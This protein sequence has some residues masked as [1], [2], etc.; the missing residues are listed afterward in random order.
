MYNLNVKHFR[1]SH[2][3]QLRNQE[4]RAAYDEILLVFEDKE[5]TIEYVAEAFDDAK[6]ESKKLVILRNLNKK[7]HL[8]KTIRELTLNRFDYFTVIT[9]TVKTALKS[10]KAAERAAAKI[11]SEWLEPYKK[12]LQRPLI[13]VQ[14]TLIEE[15]ADE[16]DIKPRIDD[17]I[18]SLDL[19]EVLDS[20]KI[21][22]ADIKASINK[23]NS[24]M[25]A[26]NRKAHQTKRS[27]YAKMVIFLNSVEMVLN[28]NGEDKATYLRYANEVNRH[29][30]SYKATILSR[31][32]RYKNAAEKDEATSDVDNN[33]E[34]GIETTSATTE[35]NVALRSTPY[36]LT[37][38]IDK[39]MDMDMQSKEKTN[40]DSTTTDALTDNVT[41][42][43]NGVLTN[44]TN[45]ASPAD[46]STAAHNGANKID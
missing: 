14:T 10:P 3:M 12:S 33:A 2:L 43:G 17:A 42:N 22:T 34:G 30:D 21:A 27:A 24:D 18:E 13:A 37:S 8:T 20:I 35:S 32:T 45:G 40:E 9:D 25:M 5:I 46:N 29:L 15:M 31:S 4:I 1:A 39:G 36:N 16:V 6:A 19:T 38:S 44:K 11:L 26:E 23:R 7:H 41:K 28:S